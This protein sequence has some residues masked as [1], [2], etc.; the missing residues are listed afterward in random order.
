MSK[1]INKRIKY[2]L[3]HIGGTIISLISCAWMPWSLRVKWAKF[4][5][6]ITY[7]HPDKHPTFIAFIEEANEK[8]DMGK[9]KQGMYKKIVNEKEYWI[10]QEE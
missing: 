8:Y 2:I 4:I 6:K 1:N 10:E 5:Y 7:V 9:R 3:I